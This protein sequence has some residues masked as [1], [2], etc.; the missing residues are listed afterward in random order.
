MEVKIIEEFTDE[1]KFAK[2][3]KEY[4]Q[5]QNAVSTETHYA[6]TQSERGFLYTALI[7]TTP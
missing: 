7:I 6:I 4:L 1:E 5:K 3:I 2:R